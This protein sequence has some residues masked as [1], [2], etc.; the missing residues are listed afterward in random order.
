[1]NRYR[2][3]FSGRVDGAIGKFERLSV[4]VTA[5]SIF[6]DSIIR[7]LREL[8]YE[9]ERLICRTLI[10]AESDGAWLQRMVDTHGH[11]GI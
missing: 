6:S 7:A 10:E 3:L 5:E 4:D 9:T 11:G 8:G 1:M 2:I